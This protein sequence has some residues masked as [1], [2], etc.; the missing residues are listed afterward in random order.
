MARSRVVALDERDPLRTFKNK[1]VITDPDTCY[2]DGN[3]LGRLPHATV[4]AISDFL[5][6]EWGKENVLGWSRWIDEAQQVGD[7]IGRSALGAAP[8]QVLAADTTSVNLYQLAG[9]ALRARPGRKRIITDAANF[10]TDRYILASLAKAHEMELT[11]IDNEGGD[12][13]ELISPD[14]LAE[15]L[16]EDVA[17]VSL[18]VIQ[19]RSGARQAVREITELAKKTGT[20]LLWDAAHAIGS[21]EL[22]FDRD[23]VELAVGC[24]Y[25]YGNSGPGAPAWLYVA[26]SIQ[27]ELQV[28]IQGWFAQRDQ[29]AMGPEFERDQ[30]IRG[31]QIASPSIL[32]LRSVRT[33]F[34]MIEAAGISKIAA[35]A[36][37]GTDLMI[38]LFDAWLAHLGFELLTP[39]GSGLRGGHITIAHPEAER[40]SV[41]LRKFANVVADYRVPNS[42]RLAISPLTTSFVEVYDGFE[43]IR[44]L[45]A[46]RK[47]EQVEVGGSRVT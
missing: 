41:A 4:K 22:A 16:S 23:G 28:P 18:Q 7:L 37:E 47:Y 24:T 45:V 40:I 27:P 20:L 31:F 25:K 32:G 19:Y 44:D 30:S 12:R 17:L 13:S 10:P 42:I 14:S 39:R 8:G 46:R 15:Y 3:S 11:V 9:A 38:E 43:R 26:K 2:L 6:D 1:F 5:H 34:E 36:A 29:F 33:A 21:I 35:K